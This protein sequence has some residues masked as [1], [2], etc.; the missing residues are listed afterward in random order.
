MPAVVD[1][2]GQRYGR[3]VVLERHRGSRRNRARV[4]CAC[5]C[6]ATATVDPRS[7]ANGDTRS[8]GC[9]RRERSRAFMW[10]VNALGLNGKRFAFARLTRALGGGT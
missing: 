1:R 2:S 9:L 7:L 4:T 10:S 3:L 6:G 5:D 8:C